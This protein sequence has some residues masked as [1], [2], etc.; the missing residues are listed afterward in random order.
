MSYDFANL[1]PAD[2]EDLVRELI[3]QELKI[4]FEAF[5][6]G[7]DGGM[8]GRH[9]AGAKATILQAK[10]YAGSTFAKLKSALKKERVCIDRILPKP[11]RYVLATRP[12]TPP[13]KA[14]L[15]TIIGKALKTEGDIFGPAISTSC[16]TDFQTSRS[17]ISSS[18]Y[19][20]RPCSNGSFVLRRTRLRP[21]HVPTSRQK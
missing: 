4:R 3:G 16:F 8:D 12:L 20:A 19:Q 9:A 2:F 5:G 17:R 6:A 1:S 11:K 10:H 18:G 14:A 21:C 7:P 13:D 15:A